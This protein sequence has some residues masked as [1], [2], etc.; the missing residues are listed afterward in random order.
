MTAPAQ[1]RVPRKRWELDYFGLTP[2][3]RLKAKEK[4]R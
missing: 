4:A 3:L 2:A 1:P